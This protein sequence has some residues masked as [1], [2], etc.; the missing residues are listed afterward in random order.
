MRAE[1]L[2]P[3][4]SEIWT[5][6]EFWSRSHDKLIWEKQ[7]KQDVFAILLAAYHPGIRLLG[8]STVFGN[9]PLEYVCKCP[10]FSSCAR[11][12]SGARSSTRGT[13]KKRMITNLGL[14]KQ[15]GTR[16]V[17]SPPSRNTTKSP[18]TR[19]PPR[20]CSARTSRRM[21]RTSTASPAWTAR[22]CSRSP[23]SPRGPMSL[24]WKLRRPRSVR[25]RRGQ[26]G[27][28]RRAV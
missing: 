8:I 19:A 9:A 18:S 1:A 3:V 4:A 13:K 28:W 21:P 16:P 5:S 17:S 27:W 15:L 26:P 25:V 6:E 2:L 24:P 22:R 7:H 20:R 10:C 14:E 11:V 12:G 23:L